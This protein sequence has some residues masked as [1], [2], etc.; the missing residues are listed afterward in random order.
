[1]AVFDSR[2]Q[3]FV[4]IGDIS[5]GGFSGDF[6]RAVGAVDALDRMVISWVAPPYRVQKKTAIT[7][8]SWV[9]VM[10]TSESSAGIDIQGSTGF[11]RVVAP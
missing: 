7:N 6:D 1:M 10:T 5:E 8:A 4:A 3:S 11:F 9:D 2:D